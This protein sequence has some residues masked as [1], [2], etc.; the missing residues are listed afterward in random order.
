MHEEGYSGG[1]V[2][3][4]GAVTASPSR[5]LKIVIENFVGYGFQKSG[6]DL[7]QQKNR[8][9]GAISWRT[10]TS[11]ILYS[12]VVISNGSAL[13]GL[14]YISFFVANVNFDDDGRLKVNVNQFANDNVWNGE[15]R[16]RV[17]VP[18]LTRIS[19]GE[20]RYGYRGITLPEHIELVCC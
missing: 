9:V 3:L 4:Y 2:L 20:K 10:S 14:L 5:S 8:S 17:V 1:A 19:L 15:N 6:F 18:L 13:D 11:Q 16:H 7:S 12:R